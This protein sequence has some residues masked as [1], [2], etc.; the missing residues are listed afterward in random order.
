MNNFRNEVDWNDL[1]S[2]SSIETNRLLF[3]NLLT[4]ATER[5]VPTVSMKSQKLKPPWW[6][7][8]LASDI[9]IKRK[10]YLKYMQ[11]SSQTDYH[12]YVTQRNLVKSRVRSAQIS[13]EDYLIKR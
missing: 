11:T 10:L 3:K 4:I 6:N 5:Y 8:S 12:N 13:Y 1:L 2:D 7:K 9:A